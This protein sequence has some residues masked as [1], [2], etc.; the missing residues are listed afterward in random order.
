[1]HNEACLHWV[2]QRAMDFPCVCI[3]I[4]IDLPAQLLAQLATALKA[5]AALAPSR[6]QLQLDAGKKTRDKA[7]VKK[8]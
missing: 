6:W 4:I 7:A 8:S 5:A 1:M 3:E 2:A